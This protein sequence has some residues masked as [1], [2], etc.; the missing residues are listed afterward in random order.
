MPKSKSKKLK[1]APLLKETHDAVFSGMN[2]ILA[3]EGLS[4]ANPGKDT[5]R[6]G[7]ALTEFYVR[8]IAC[9]TD[10]ISDEDAIERGLECDGAHDM[11]ID[12]AYEF[13]GESRFWICQSKH[14][15]GNRPL[16]SE[17]ISEFFGIYA[18]ISKKTTMK[19]AKRAVR[20]LLEDFS[21]PSKQPSA[22]F[23]LLTSGKITPGVREEFDRKKQETVEFLAG[24]AEN[25]DWELVGLSE[26][27]DKHGQAKSAE[28]KPPTVEIPVASF[29]GE[30][31][32]KGFIDLSSKIAKPYKTIVTAICGTALRKMWKEHGRSLF[33]QN[34]RGFLGAGGKKNKNIIETL[35]GK[36][37]FFF[38]F[39]NGISAIC[40]ELIP[41]KD[42]GTTATCKGFQIINGAQTV[43][44]IGEFASL[45]GEENLEK[46]WVLARVTQTEKEKSDAQKGLNRKIITFNNTQNFIRDADFHSND[47]IQ[48]FLEKE[49]QT[50]GFQY[51]GV[52]PHKTLVY[53]PKRMPAPPKAGKI[54]ITMDDMAKSQFA[55]MEDEPEKLNSQT[56]FLFEEPSE[57]SKKGAYEGAYW[58][59]FG[60]GGNKEVN[61]LYSNVVKRFAA[62][63]ALNC[64][65]NAEIA[66]LK[67]EKVKKNGTTTDEARY[68]SDTA[69][70]M[71]IRSGR[72]I[73]WAFGFAIRN[74]YPGEEEKIHDCLLSVRAFAKDGFAR[75]WFERI[76]TIM[77]DLLE[78]ESDSQSGKTLN[79]KMWLR[80][81]RK[82]ESLMRELKKFHK[83]APIKL[84]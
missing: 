25:L 26:I 21:E 22:T 15:S 64:F 29:D 79:F 17:E 41:P 32:S 9:H 45:H 67:K 57:D 83:L 12:F 69:K 40:D 19:D 39:N 55:F 53:M 50:R 78:A 56:G 27:N 36:P 61:R 16:K 34:I 60:D 46:V 4:I 42:G 77:E 76:T 35:K 63:L 47:K 71:V 84:D 14:K 66:A 24:L 65:I 5:R 6:V 38:L 49:F 43:C 82:V 81:H 8:E 20:E 62:V 30:K 11:N 51:R 80:D 23:V 3:K 74:F 70:G 59:I 75:V 58:R 13:P 18:K 44:S 52:T 54:I 28:K 37:E 68:P 72:H 73:L 48:V 10:D 33:N 31:A 7:K 1:P 2:K